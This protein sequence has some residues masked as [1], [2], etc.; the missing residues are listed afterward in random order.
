MARQVRTERLLADYRKS[1]R[2]PV[3]A[4]RLAFTGVGERDVYNVSGVFA[5]P[6]DSRPL[7]AGRVEDRSSEWSVVVVFAESDGAWAPVEG[8]TSLTLQDPFVFHHAG[9]RYLGGVEIA[10]ATDADGKPVLKWRTVVLDH[11]DPAAPVPAFEGPWGMKDLRFVD[12]AD[13]RLGVLTRPQGGADGRGRIGFTAVGSLADLTVQD[14]DEAP[15]L[16]DLFL[17]EEWG[18]VNHAWLLDDG[19]IGLLGHIAA[20]GDAGDRHYYPIVFSLDPKTLEYTVPRILFER[21]D[22]PEGPSKRPDLEDVIFPG[23][24]DVTAAR[25]AVYCGVADAEAFRVELDGLF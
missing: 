15:R 13:G 21:R 9:V 24:V 5:D 11:R 4:E 6:S 8:A 17:A 19:T 22:L 2:L 18:G 23:W 16:E 1:G 10:E 14:I 7:I 20:F 12:L 25:P 3:R